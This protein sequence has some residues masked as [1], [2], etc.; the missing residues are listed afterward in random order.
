MANYALLAC[1]LIV[2]LA[3]GVVAGI[4]LCGVALRWVMSKDDGNAS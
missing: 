3:A 2:F 4:W 1:G